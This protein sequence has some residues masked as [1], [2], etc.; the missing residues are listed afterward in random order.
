MLKQEVVDEIRIAIYE[1]LGIL[2][3]IYSQK[4]SEDLVKDVK[5]YVP[6]ITQADL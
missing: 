2:Y 3:D 1:E 5:E 4:W 6:E